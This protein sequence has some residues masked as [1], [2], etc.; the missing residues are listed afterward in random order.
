[1]AAPDFH[2]SPGGA[3]TIT[4]AIGGVAGEL[5]A[6]ARQQQWAELVAD[7][8]PLCEEQGSAVALVCPPDVDPTA[9]D[10]WLG[11][12]G[13]AERPLRSH[14]VPLSAGVR[15]ASQAV[16][17]LPADRLLDAQ[18]VQVVR[19]ELFPR[20]GGSYAIVI[21]AAALATADDLGFVEQTA[22][23]LLVQSPPANRPRA[24]LRDHHVFLWSAGSP[25]DF[26]AE[27]F[28]ADRDSLLSRVRGPGASL[29]A[30]LAQQLGTLIDR[31]AEL[32]RQ[33]RTGLLAQQAGRTQRLSAQLDAV[34]ALRTRLTRHLEADGQL[35]VAQV[36]G[37]MRQ[38]ASEL[39][40]ATDKA[41]QDAF[42][43]RRSIAPDDASTIVEQQLRGADWT[44]RTAALIQT[45]QGDIQRESE[46]FLEGVDWTL[47]NEVSH[48]QDPRAQY[49]Y[50]LLVQV[51]EQL[52]PLE[53]AQLMSGTLGAPKVQRNLLARN[54]VVLGIPVSLGA[55]SV[56]WLLIV[57]MPMSFGLL[58]GGLS[59]LLA[60]RKQGGCEYEQCRELARQA[61]QQFLS[62]SVAYFQGATQLIA[63]Q[64]RQRLNDEVRE[65]EDLLRSA[66]EASHSHGAL[67][68][69]YA[70]TAQL[71]LLRFRLQAFDAQ[72]RGAPS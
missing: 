37:A 67:H 11:Q 53:P 19:S 31:A 45:R 9:F 63:A 35:L 59:S 46:E 42:A 29:E 36:A 51:F 28:G 44:R 49:P 41:L 2:C 60:S 34:D 6:L 1:V 47:V 48:A 22:W 24:L 65:I 14:F 33:R 38:W 71:E 64:L 8:A 40:S 52:M 27:R 13:V 3:I 55:I 21:A 32:A 20:P 26:L 16:A 72:A 23:R 58:V 57:P 17:L 54:L 69:D 61:V 15:L 30:L 18:E 39:E 4:S 12:A 68:G 70:L 66:L 5:L 7:T 62:R 25:P 10:R 56:A 43:S 50:R